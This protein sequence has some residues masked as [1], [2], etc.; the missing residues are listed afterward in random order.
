MFSWSMFSWA[1]FTSLQRAL[2]FG[3]PLIASVVNPG[4]GARFQTVLSQELVRPKAPTQNYKCVSP[5]S[6]P[7]IA[8][9]D[10]AAAMV[11][12]IGSYLHG[13]DF[14]NL[15]GSPLL[16]RMMP[17]AKMLLVEPWNGLIRFLG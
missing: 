9:F 6:P 7:G 12:A 17:M 1:M 14:A 4:P 8:H 15:S 3:D 16:D 13:R 11:Q 5:R 10:S 2:L